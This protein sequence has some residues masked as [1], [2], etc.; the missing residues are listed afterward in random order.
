MLVRDAG[1]DDLRFVVDLLGR[2]GWAPPEL[3]AWTRNSSTLVLYDPADGIVRGAIV[4]GELAPGSFELRAWAVE[5]VPDGARATGRLVRAAADHL[6]RAGG[7]RL[8]VKIHKAEVA[9]DVLTDA[10][11]GFNNNDSS[12]FFVVRGGLNFK[13]NTF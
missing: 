12:D 6:R 4:V 5:D 3:A 7:E 2:A 9:V 8:V 11:F 1:P 13:F 10:G